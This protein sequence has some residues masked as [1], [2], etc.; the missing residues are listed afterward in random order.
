MVK[1]K[2]LL[3]LLLAV[4]I[5]SMASVTL[6]W[7]RVYSLP[8][9]QEIFKVSAVEDGVYAFGYTDEKGINEDMLI[10]KFD[11]QGNLVYENSLGGIYND[12]VNSGGV[13]SDGDLVI[14]GTSGSYGSDFDIYFNKIGKNKF[15]KNL[16]KLGQDKGSDYI[17]VNDGF[18]VIGYGSDPDT[19]NMRGIIA[20][21][22]KSGNVVYQKWLP[23]FVPGSDT[24]PLSIE[25]TTDG[26]F[27][28]AGTVVQI[29]DNL[30]KFY[31]TKVDK[32]GEEIW[33]KVFS[34]R[35]YARG[36][37]VKEVPGGYVAV[38]Y[39]GS[40]KTKWSDIYVVKVDYNGNIVWERS[41][42]DVEGDHG[43]SLAVAP[44]GNIFVTGY[45]T[46]PNKDYQDKDIIILEYDV[47]GNLLSER[48]IG[49]YGDDVAFSID[50]DKNGNLY[51]GGFSES[52]D[53]GADDMRDAFVLKYSIK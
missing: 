36:F 16:T 11:L 6:D 27:I 32:N 51:L 3:V 29:F 37:D 49:G 5:I 38:G 52:P 17:E 1:T 18:I 4:S 28:I 44:N 34:P 33:T 2:I 43:Y 12:W 42:G 41:Y 22:D 7:G 21:L 40:W 39:E 19:L 50:I 53:L 26:N 23:Y 35:E 45:V 47:N 15:S 10:L 30:T 48:I 25:Q 24:K 9:A 31:L 20:K 46:N 14:I 13:A 8:G